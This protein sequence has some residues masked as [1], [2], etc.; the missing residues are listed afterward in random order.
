MFDTK[1]GKP[2][3]FILEGWIDEASTNV[4]ILTLF[5][6]TL[7]TFVPFAARCVLKISSVFV[8]NLNQLN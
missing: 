5:F 7:V 4:A 2:R 3:H 1:T 8:P 6:Y